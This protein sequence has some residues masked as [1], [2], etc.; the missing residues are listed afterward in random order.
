MLSMKQTMDLTKK[1]M[2][3]GVSDTTD[4]I[5][6]HSDT[7]QLLYLY[8]EDPIIIRGP[9]KYSK[10]DDSMRPAQEI[11]D[12][13]EHH[14]VNIG[15]FNYPVVIDESVTD[16]S[17]MFAYCNSFDQPILIPKGTLHCDYMFYKCLAYNCAIEFERHIQTY[18]GAL[19]MCNSLKSP[20]LIHSNIEVPGEMFR[21]ATRTFISDSRTEEEAIYQ[22]QPVEV[23]G[24]IQLVRGD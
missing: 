23:P 2:Q 8:E 22:S 12:W 6:S 13:C 3:N 10:Y 15:D 16:C 24:Y 7:E 11:V 4:W 17:A 14:Q 9:G 1:L 19:Y 5:A 18:K 21:H 20:V